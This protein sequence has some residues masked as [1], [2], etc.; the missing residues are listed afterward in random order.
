MEKT[1]TAEC[2]SCESSYD[3][4]YVQ[5]LTSEEYPEFCPFCGEPI[6]ELSESNYIE[7]DELD[8]DDKWD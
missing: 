7:D 5:E 8:N 3:V 4:E 2:S 6:D 1:I